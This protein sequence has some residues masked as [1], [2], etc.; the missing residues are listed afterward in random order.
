MIPSKAMEYARQAYNLSL[1]LREPSADGWVQF[2]L[3]R[4]YLL[5]GEYSNA[6]DAFIKSVRIRDDLGQPFL[7]MEPLAGL[8]ETALLMGDR[9]QASATLE[10]I[11]GHLEK[12]GSLEGT[13]DPFRVY[14]I[15]HQ[16][17]QEQKDP[18]AR[19][20]L[21]NANQLLEAQVSKFNDETVRKMFVES[22]PWRKAIYD[23]AQ[24]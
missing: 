4:A 11:L 10:K 14:H 9:D 19:Q 12:G 5:L 1:K 24:A 6:R 18:R 8:V 7:S 17:L 21:L 23:A 15:C 20:L 2:Y 13:D 22:F 3:G 16:F